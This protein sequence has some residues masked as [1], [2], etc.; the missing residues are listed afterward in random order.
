MLRTDAE[1]TFKRA[2]SWVQLNLVLIKVKGI[3]GGCL[4]DVI[5]DKTGKPKFIDH[6]SQDIVHK[7]GTGEAKRH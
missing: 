2:A 4:R 6:V 5:S 7:V 1:R 3:Q